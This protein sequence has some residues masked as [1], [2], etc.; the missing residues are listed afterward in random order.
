MVGGKRS[1]TGKANFPGFTLCLL[2]RGGRLFKQEQFAELERLG[3]PEIIS[4]EGPGELYDLE[5]LT[6][7]FP[8]IRFL[9]LHEE[10]SAGEQV[11]MALEEASGEY[12]IVLWNDMKIAPGSLSYRLLERIIKQEALCVVPILQNY[13]LETIPTIQAPAFY[14]TLLKVVPLYPSADGMLTLFPYDFVGIYSRERFILSGGYDYSL[15][16]PYWQKMDFGFRNYMWGE[17]ILCQTA[18]RFSYIN[19]PTLEDNTPDHSYRF[20]YL[21]NLA[22]RFNGEAG[23]LPWRKFLPYSMKAGSGF[24]SGL[25]DFKEVRRWVQVNQ[26]RFKQDARSVTELWEVPEV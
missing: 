16:N 23:V 17:K 13:K 8:T 9:L 7:K 26:Y 1:A 22:V 5:S 6:L 4:L 21:K 19:D 25:S 10:A 20:F 15:S 11:N 14:K 24:F 18:L 12:V 3:F 2:N